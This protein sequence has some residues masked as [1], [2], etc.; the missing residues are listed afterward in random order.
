[1]LAGPIHLQLQPGVVPALPMYHHLNEAAF[2]P[3]NDFLQR[4]T[5]DPLARR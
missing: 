4:R 3:H 1:M 2:D 5:Q